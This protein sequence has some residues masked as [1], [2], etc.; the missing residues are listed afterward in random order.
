MVGPS[1]VSFSLRK[2]Y[3][4]W[5]D[6]SLARL[7]Q[8]QKITGAGPPPVLARRGARVYSLRSPEAGQECGYGFW[9]DLAQHI[10]DGQFLASASADTTISVWDLKDT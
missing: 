8:G 2:A 5:A 3:V 9:P 6:S 10:D 4:R 1:S 7:W